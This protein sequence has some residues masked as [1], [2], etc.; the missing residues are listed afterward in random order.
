MCAPV[1]PAALLF[2]VSDRHTLELKTPDRG[3]KLSRTPLQD[4]ASV[5]KLPWASVSPPR[6]GITG[7]TSQEQ[8]LVAQGPGA[9]GPAVC[10]DQPALAGVFLP[11]SPRG[12]WKTCS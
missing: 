2:T 10:N 6:T 9:R 5:P 4:A 1:L 12:W 8:K 3:L 11:T 7:T